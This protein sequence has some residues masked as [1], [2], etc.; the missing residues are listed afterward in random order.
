MYRLGLLGIPNTL[1]GLP[2]GLMKTGRNSQRIFCVTFLS[3][4]YTLIYELVDWVYYTI[5]I[6]SSRWSCCS[7]DDDDV[8]SWSIV[9]TIHEH[10]SSNARRRW[11]NVWGCDKLCSRVNKS[12]QRCRKLNLMKSAKLIGANYFLW[13]HHIH[14]YDCIWTDAVNNLWMELLEDFLENRVCHC[15]VASMKLTV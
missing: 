13:E 5:S 6:E 1:L 7:W 10:S 2:A 8:S 3:F 12:R 14:I 9:S 15:N 4:N 11:T